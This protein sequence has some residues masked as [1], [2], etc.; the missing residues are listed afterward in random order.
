MTKQR[1]TIL[2]IVLTVLIIQSCKLQETVFVKEYPI[3]RYADSVQLIGSEYEIELK[4]KPT[5]TNKNLE[6]IPYETNSYKCMT[7]RKKEYKHR[8][9]RIGKIIFNYLGSSLLVT[10]GLAAIDWEA[11]EN[12]DGSYSFNGANLVFAGASILGGYLFYRSTKASYWTKYETIYDIQPYKYDYFNNEKSKM[13]KQP[14][15]VN[16]NNQSQTYKSD[17]FGTVAISLT[18]FSFPAKIEQHK[19]YPFSF[20]YNRNNFTNKI[21]LNTSDWYLTYGKINSPTALFYTNG[22]DS[23][24]TTLPKGVEGKILENNNYPGK[25]FVNIDFEYKRGWLND[26]YLDY[27]YALNYNLPDNETI[28]KKNEIIAFEK[29]HSTNNFMKYIEAYPNSEKIKEA[30]QLAFEQVLIQNTIEAYTKFINIVN[31]KKLTDSITIKRNNLVFDNFATWNEF[32]KYETFKQEYPD[33]DISLAIA[34]ATNKSGKVTF[35]HE[36]GQKS[37]IGA[38][39]NN[40]KTGEW[41]EWNDLGNKTI[42]ATYE[43]NLVH[44]ELISFYENGNRK[45]Y[46]EMKNG[47]GN[48]KLIQ[49]YENGQV[50]FAGTTKNEKP[51]GSTTHYYE[52][53]KKKTYVEYQNGVNH[54]K[55]IGYYENGKIQ[56]SYQ[57]KNGKL[58]GKSISYYENGKKELEGYAQNGVGN[59]TFTEYYNNGRKKRR[60]QLL[61]GKANGNW[62]F[63]DKNGK[64]SKT[65]NYKNGFCTNCPGGI[66]PFGI[67]QGIFGSMFGN[68]PGLR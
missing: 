2:I 40:L 45:V 60:G 23:I 48:G 67:F 55:E 32:E 53:G 64:L 27:F 58:H 10:G 22:L 15:S 61:N 66:N 59:G 63:W 18:D 44:G 38:Y 13:L 47:K 31:D 17:I 51:H 3:Q 56:Y 4:Q 33:I 43:N 16:V 34:N 14:F 57:V 36:N 9:R 68:S 42:K 25:N 49:Y 39:K 24:N 21:E 11:A 37:S 7:Y 65:E 6:V 30:N 62:Q 46:A 50:K 5:Q 54:G 52:N 19:I 8:K 12:E 1:I 28:I 20:A 41:T 26:E 29:A 35:W